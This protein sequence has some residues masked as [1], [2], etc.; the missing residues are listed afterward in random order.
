[1]KK[2][3]TCLIGL[4][5]VLFLSLPFYTTASADTIYTPP[6][7]SNGYKVYL[8]PAKHAAENTGCNN[9]KES[10]NARLI[11]TES[12][13]DLQAMGYTVRV[14][15]GD[16]VA[17]TTSSNDWKPQL[18]V[19]IHSNATTFDCA[20]T[21]PKRGGTWLMYVS[22]NG[23][24]AA[25]RILAAMGSS[26][27]GTNDRKLTDVEATGGTLYELR[28]TVA[29][30]A[31]VEAAFHTYGP[32]VS[33][34]LQHGTVGQKITNGIHSY[35]GAKDCRTQACA[36]TSTESVSEQPTE[37]YKMKEHGYDLDTFGKRHSMLE[38]ELAALLDGK[39][40][41]SIFNN[42]TKHMLNGVAINEEG[43][44][45]V[46]FKDFRS[47]LGS[48]SAYLSSEL[49]QRLSEVVFKHPEIKEVYFQFDGSISD[50]HY[51]LQTVEE[52]MK[53]H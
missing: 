11:A 20:G 26:S 14:G 10:A 7:K 6:G 53:R 27:P 5:I 22:T 25:E 45:I 21:N 37:P 18:H 2:K 51:W 31:Y 12:A 39:Q 38:K 3:L 28:R 46:D 4:S 52:P 17:N 43:T 41:G 19:P 36:A 47:Q 8:S 13:K 48:P 49:N 15:S 32:D 9:Y 50:W 24:L 29:V 16:Y 44:A 30:A 34:L 35:S 33:W 23:N 42:K 40:S 1:M